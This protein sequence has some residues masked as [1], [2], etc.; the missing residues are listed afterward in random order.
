MRLNMNSEIL[1]LIYCFDD[2]YNIQGI[3]SANSFLKNYK[4]KVRIHIL[5]NNPDSIKKLYDHLSN[6]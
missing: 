5:H 2:N 3:T 1:D 4:N 6:D